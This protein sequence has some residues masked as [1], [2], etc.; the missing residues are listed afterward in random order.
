MNETISSMALCAQCK[1]FTFFNDG[2]SMCEMGRHTEHMKAEDNNWLT[3]C[4]YWEAKH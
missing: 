4:Q 3:D 1:H 2:L